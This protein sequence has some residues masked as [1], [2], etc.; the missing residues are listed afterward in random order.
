MLRGRRSIAAA[1]ATA[2][3][4]AACGGEAASITTDDE[5]RD[6]IVA[7]VRDSWTLEGRVDVEVSD[8]Q[9]DAVFAAIA[10]ADPATAGDVEA[11]RA[12]V[13][14]MRE[15]AATSRSLAGRAE[16]GSVRFASSL[17]GEPVF[18]LRL[19]LG[20]LLAAD[21]LT[22][23]VTALVQVD[24]SAMLDQFRQSFEMMAE[25]DPELGLDDTPELPSVEQMRAQVSL[26]L[27]SGPVQDMVLAILD[28]RFGGA[29]GILDLTTFGATEDDLTEAREEFLAEVPITAEQVA[30]VL[31][32]ALTF[33]DFDTADG[34]TTA[35]VDLHPRDAVVA[36]GT[37]AEELGET[38]DW[39]ADF[40]ADGTSLEDV[41]ETVPGVATVRY[42]G[43]GHLR[44]VTVPVLDIVREVVDVLPDVPTEVAAVLAELDG[45][46]YD[47][48][49]DISDVGEV[50]TLLDVD[51]VTVPWQ[52]IV[53]LVEQMG[54]GGGMDRGATDAAA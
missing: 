23:E 27:P 9:L 10:E 45:A 16:D 1:A 11:M 33:R 5:A 50:D 42:D 28:G 25:V 35:T 34:M 8:A 20:A 22:P 48:V 3:L 14:S 53:E 12:V 43:A 47:L 52:D 15:Q 36:A 38:E 26:F 7:T 46:R 37:I 40:E 32:A 24:V 17:D 29:T 30:E 44:G 6:A 31:D 21:T 49:V 4:L 39:Q 13:A 51:A 18:D 41:P 19:D 54:M 2:G